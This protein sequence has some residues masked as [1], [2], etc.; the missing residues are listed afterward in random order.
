MRDVVRLILGILFVAVIATFFA[1]F[2]RDG[3]HGEVTLHFAWSLAAL[4]AL[5]VISEAFNR[6]MDR[7]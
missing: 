5:F 3:S 7:K 4:F 1:T 2:P 6:T